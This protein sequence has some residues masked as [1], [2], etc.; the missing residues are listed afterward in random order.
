M[1]ILTFRK[2]INMKIAILEDNIF[3]QQKIIS[4]L[5]LGSDLVHVYSDIDS[6]NL[7]NIYYDLLLLDINLNKYNGID[8]IKKHENKQLFIIYISN[9]E[10]YMIDV[11][12]SNV[13]GFIP[14]IKIDNLLVSKIEFAR[15]KIQNVNRIILSIIGGKIE[16]R[17]NDVVR[18]YLLEGNLYISLEGNKIHR[19]TYDTLKDVQQYFSSDF[20]RVNNSEVVNLSKIKSIDNKN[21]LIVLNNQQKIKVSRRRWKLIKATGYRT[22]S[23][24]SDFGRTTHTGRILVD[25]HSCSFSGKGCYHIYLLYPIQ[26]FPFYFLSRISQSRFILFKP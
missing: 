12:D 10:E 11:F 9:Y 23:P 5:N 24:K 15:K 16:I 8:Y 18:F 21:H 2:G 22:D 17:E 20:L 26:F 6:Y 25:L 4:L 7:S 3:F 14:K 1:R 19:L 13:L